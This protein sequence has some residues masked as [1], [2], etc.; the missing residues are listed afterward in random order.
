[1]VY[2]CIIS[3]VLFL[4]LT[5]PLY[6]AIDG[7]VTALFRPRWYLILGVFKKGSEKLQSQSEGFSRGFSSLQY[8]TWRWRGGVDPENVPFWYIL[9][10]L[11]YS[12]GINW[13]FLHVRFYKASLIINK[14][15]RM[16]EQPISMG[17]RGEGGNAN[18]PITPLP[19]SL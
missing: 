17:R 13:W 6:T 8:V 19:P 9:R 16:G 1:M 4:L 5:T 15:S 14:D 3:T 10:V 2:L 7:A 12:Q 11:I 18:Q